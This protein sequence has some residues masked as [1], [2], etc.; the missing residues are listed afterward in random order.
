[1]TDSTYLVLGA[2]GRQ[3]S[4]VV[5]ALVA[6][7]AKSIV[8]T[9]RDPESETVKKL[10]DI[11]VVT[12]ALKVDLNDIDSIKTAMIESEAQRV[13]FT[14]DYYSIKSANRSKEAQLGHNVI[15]AVKESGNITHVVQSSVAD[16]DACPE[17]IQHFWGKADIETFMKEELPESGSITWSII[18]PVAYFENLDDAKNYNP[19]KKGSVKMLTKADCKV[20]YVACEDIGKGSA[21][22]LMDPKKYAGKTIEAVTSVHNGVDLAKALTKVSGVECTYYVGFPRFM[23]WLLMTD[24]YHMVEWYETDDYP[25]DA[26]DEIDEFKKLV[27]DAMDAEAWF[28]KKGQWANGEKFA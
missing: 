2:T 28:T 14:T 12:K 20:K 15:N 17:P 4:A 7:G 23:L 27:P 24:L 21:E 3:G 22:M 9:S 1:M 8:I 6:K 19:L 13:W 26:S 11:D 10:L 16:A 25:N 18:R 5:H